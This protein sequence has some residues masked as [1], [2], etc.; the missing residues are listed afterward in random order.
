MSLIK[1]TSDLL[2]K[3]EDGMELEI[4]MRMVDTATVLGKLSKYTPKFDPFLEL[5]EYKNNYKKSLRI[6]KEAGKIKKELYVKDRLY[7]VFG[8][9]YSI[10]LSTETDIK[11]TTLDFIPMKSSFK[12]RFSYQHPES[13]LW[14]VDFT[15]ILDIIDNKLITKEFIHTTLDENN[16]IEKFMK[17]YA[18]NSNKYS[19][20]LEIEYV[21]KVA[22]TEIP[23]IYVLGDIKGGS[24]DYMTVLHDVAK[25]IH[26][27]EY[28]R[29]RR[30]TEPTIK[31][32]LPQ[33]K[34]LTKIKYIDEIFP[35]TNYLATDKADGIRTL[36]YAIDEKVY[37]LHSTINMATLKKAVNI[38][39]LDAEMIG[40]KIYLFD[41]LKVNGND[42]TMSGIETRTL[43]LLE[44]SNLLNSLQTDY[45]FEPKTYYKL[46]DIST[47]GRIFT[48]VSEEISEYH[49]DGVILVSKQKPY[50]QTITYKWK[51][52]QQQTFDFLAV[53]VPE[54]YATRFD[55]YPGRTLYYLFC[56]IHINEMVNLNLRL[57][58]GFSDMFQNI[59]LRS[60]KYIPLQF[61]LPYYPMAYVF[62][63]SKPDLHMKIV[64]VNINNTSGI[65]TGTYINWK[66]MKVREDRQCIIGKYYGN[67]YKTVMGIFVNYIDP[68]PLT[69]LIKGFES[70]NYFMVTKSPRYAEYTKAMS[71]VKS[72]MMYDFIKPNTTVMDIGAGKGQDIFRYPKL[73]V[74]TILAIDKDSNALVRLLDRWMSMFIHNTSHTARLNTTLYTMV[75]DMNT[76]YT[77]NVEYV[78]CKFPLTYNVI[79][80]NLAVHYFL[81]SAS[82]MCNFVS[83]CSEVTE[84]SCII[85]ITCLEGKKVYEKLQNSSEYKLDE[86]GIVKF[87]IKKMYSDNILT[88]AGQKI[89][90]LLPFSNNT[91]YS[92]YLVNTDALT[93]EFSKQGFK[94]HAHRGFGDI[95]TDTLSDVD[96]EYL[97]L[98]TLIVYKKM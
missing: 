3:F 19:G 80:C 38:H 35:P 26:T 46:D 78:T 90:V 8:D 66:L 15:I 57:V 10:V 43:H 12:F 50:L 65:S 23:S 29:N 37:I 73:N 54:K 77:N 51:P 42:I 5:T 52:I 61:T 72:K 9:S 93:E 96:K 32:I 48:N 84:P 28:I 60:D 89:E 2:K 13:K 36:V 95:Y 70:D 53:K 85:F 44:V 30:I 79:V 40:G 58:E 88:S 1:S 14:R 59:N 27:E 49:R 71:I 74:K 62:Y 7:Y 11:D 31:F 22:P 63:S 91:Y 98:F 64:E 39:I 81:E 67:N 94:L 47:Y 76:P 41:A 55:S 34:D 33:V 68:F 83:F 87:S 16:T 21:G 45:I 75:M 56:G 4:R 82:S 97:S 24:N 6:R 69:T 20:A 86:D 17:I 92:E 25:H 18:T